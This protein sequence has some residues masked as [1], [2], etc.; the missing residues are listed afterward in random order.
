MIVTARHIHR[1]PS[2][3][4]IIA[5]ALRGD[6]APARFS[7]DAMRS[8]RPARLLDRLARFPAVGMERRPP[9]TGLALPAGK[10]PEI[11][12]TRTFS[13]ILCILKMFGLSLSGRPT[14]PRSLVRASS[15]RPGLF[16]FTSNLYHLIMNGPKFMIETQLGVRRSSGHRG[17]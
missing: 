9:L 2:F 5:E 3:Q 4:H 7:G 6:N 14:R 8:G 15:A 13:S 12:L 16:L 17:R 10:S 1:L 11:A